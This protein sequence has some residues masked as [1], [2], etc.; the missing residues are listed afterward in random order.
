MSIHTQMQELS[1]FYQKTSGHKLKIL[2]DNFLAFYDDINYVNWFLDHMDH[3]N[4][5]KC[6]NNW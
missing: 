2:E 6:Q 5:A 3:I 1:A 4:I